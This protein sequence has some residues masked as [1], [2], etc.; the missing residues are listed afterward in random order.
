MRT[1]WKKRNVLLS[2]YRSIGRVLLVMMVNRP[3]WLSC[4]SIFSIGCLSARFVSYID[5][6]I[7]RDYLGCWWALSNLELV[8]K[9]F[10]FRVYTSRHWLFH[11]ISLQSQVYNHVPPRA[12]SFFS[13]NIQ[14]STQNKF[15]R[16]FFG[17]GD[18][19]NTF[20][21]NQLSFFSFS[22]TKVDAIPKNDENLA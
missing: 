16:F 17:K 2:P 20:V 3:F 10:G 18:F 13:S 22:L 9:L 21:S 11:S 7:S 8:D 5:L 6:C 19:I 1:I 14:K 12:L 15:Y 4:R